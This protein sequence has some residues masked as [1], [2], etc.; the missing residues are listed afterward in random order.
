MLLV[1]R[2]NVYFVSVELG[3]L[4]FSRFSDKMGNWI[5]KLAQKDFFRLEN[6]LETLNISRFHLN[7]KHYWSY[8]P[9]APQLYMD[10]RCAKNEDVSARRSL[11]ITTDRISDEHE[12]HVR[13]APYFIIFTDYDG[14][15]GWGWIVRYPSH[16]KQ[17]FFRF[18]IRHSSTN[19][20]GKHSA[21]WETFRTLFCLI[22]MFTLRKWKRETNLSCIVLKTLKSNHWK[23]LGNS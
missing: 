4:H 17:N 23:S 22:S 8:Q 15:R 21:R 11:G 10:M 13:R 18:S 6:F 2:R 19:Q 3:R 14:R 12:K 16:G 7:F 20:P 5:R 1:L 9:P